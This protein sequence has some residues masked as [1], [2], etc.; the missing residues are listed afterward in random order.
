M[1]FIVLVL[2]VPVGLLVA[3]LCSDELVRGRKWFK[4]IIGV[5]FIIGIVAFLLSN[6]SVFF[7]SIFIIIVSLISFIKSFDKK[8]IGRVIE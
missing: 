5:S 1:V 7:T 6:L 8:W 4:I 3:W 2:S